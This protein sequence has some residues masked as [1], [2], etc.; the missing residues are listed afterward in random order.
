MDGS[1]I[2]IR[3]SYDVFLFLVLLLLLLLITITLLLIIFVIF[4]KNI[5]IAII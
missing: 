5:I 4:V 1:W 2:D 3:N